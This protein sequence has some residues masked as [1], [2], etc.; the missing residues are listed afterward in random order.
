MTSPLTVQAADAARRNEATNRALLAVLEGAGVLG[1][2][3]GRP[4][5]RPGRAAA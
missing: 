4:W 2:D 5:T 3:Q 1:R